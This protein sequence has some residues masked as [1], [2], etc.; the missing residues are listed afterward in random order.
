MKILS[1][2][3]AFLLALS[4]ALLFTAC[5]GDGET[6]STA[7]SKKAGSKSSAV[8]TAVSSVET[9]SEATQ[10]E[11]TQSETTVSVEPFV[12]PADG[13]GLEQVTYNNVGTEVSIAR[14]DGNYIYIAGGNMIKKYDYSNPLSP[15]LVKEQTLIDL[16]KKM[17]MN[18]M[19]INGDYIYVGCRR[20][21]AN[22]PNPNVTNG[23]IFILNKSDLSVVKTARMTF[24]NGSTTS[25]GAEAGQ[26]HA[27]WDE[28]DTKV[29]NEMEDQ[30]GT[31]NFSEGICELNF[32]L[33]NLLMYKNMLIVNMQMR[34][35]CIFTIDANDPT[36]LTLA[37]TF[38]WGDNPVKEHQGG[39][40]YEVDGTIYYVGAGFGDGISFYDITDP[41][42]IISKARYSFYDSYLF[43]TDYSGKV[44]TYSVVV[45]YPYVYA[46]LG[47][48]ASVVNNQ[49]SVE[50]DNRL[51]GVLTINI[52]NLNKMTYNISKIADADRCEFNGTGDPQPTKIAKVGDY[53]MLNS[54]DK[55]VAVFK[56]TDKANPTYM[57]TIKI[58]DNN[59]TTLINLGDDELFISEYGSPYKT[60]LYKVHAN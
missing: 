22:I 17:N 23:A 14:R 29:G 35:W 37:D 7:S 39:A 33:S 3:T 25:Y 59:I 54:A 20:Y 18:S 1:R 34:G 15:K 30:D 5:N 58:S 9:Q 28:N 4:T 31:F 50:Y 19:V 49:P 48:A 40:V 6:S 10:S 2:V 55:G 13:F 57:K 51:M 60:Y 8:S 11:A 16:S 42:N 43:D 41:T 21:Q 47:P 24:P 26:G 44:H 38:F 45:D 52:T 36:H 53:L 46:T 12:M 32:K 56:L 27:N